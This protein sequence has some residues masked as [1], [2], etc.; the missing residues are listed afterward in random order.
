MSHVLVCTH[1][2]D[3]DIKTLLG[4]PIVS[5]SFGPAVSPIIL[6]GLSCDGSEETFLQCPSKTVTLQA[7]CGSG[8]NAAAVI[9]TGIGS[10]TESVYISS[11]NFK[12]SLQ[13][14]LVLMVQFVSWVAIARLMDEWK[15][16]WLGDGEL[17][18][19]AV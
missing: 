6:N 18:V 12:L 5:G 13:S 14:Y 17:C 8:V 11:T 7:S 19:L 2:N 3:G 4:I 10:K 15:C 9:C 1:T 16:V